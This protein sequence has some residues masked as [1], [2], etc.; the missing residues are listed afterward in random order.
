MII[1]ISSKSLETPN[2]DSAKAVNIQH[3]YTL[4][5]TLLVEYRFRKAGMFFQS[6][7]IPTNLSMEEL[8]T[9]QRPLPSNGQVDSDTL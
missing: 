4:Y 6:C 5:G 7:S 9:E 8:G 2:S 1:E 3:T